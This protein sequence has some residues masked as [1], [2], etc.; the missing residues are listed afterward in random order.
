[1]GYENM[2]M[3]NRWPGRLDL[4]DTVEEEKVSK[5]EGK[6]EERAKEEEEEERW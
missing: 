6:K 2:A 3:G 4:Y 5:C 1:M